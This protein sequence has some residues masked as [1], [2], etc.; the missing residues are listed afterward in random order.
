M[1]LDIQQLY[2]PTIMEIQQISGLHRTIQH[3]IQTPRHWYKASTAINISTTLKKRKTTHN[4]NCTE[5][6]R[7]LRR[8]TKKKRKINFK[9][10]L[11]SQAKNT[12]ISKILEF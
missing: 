1:L 3:H 6:Q 9:H 5:T 2:T 11:L 12:E 8:V 4:P 7:I 10:S